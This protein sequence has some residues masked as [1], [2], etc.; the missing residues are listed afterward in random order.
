MYKIIRMRETPLL[1]KLFKK[2]VPERPNRGVRT[3]LKTPKAKKGVFTPSVWWMHD[4]GTPFPQ[5]LVIFHPTRRLGGRLEGI[6]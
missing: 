2:Y 1:V 6:F 4:C 3:D 5:E